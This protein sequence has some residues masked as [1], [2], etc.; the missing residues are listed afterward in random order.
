MSGPSYPQ[1]RLEVIAALRSLGDPKHQRL[2]WGRWR[3]GVEYYD[4]LALDIHILYDDTGVLP[5]PEGATPAVLFPAE[6][7][8]FRALAAALGPLIDEH[9]ERGEEV[10]LRDPRWASVIAAASE[11]LAVMEQTEAGSA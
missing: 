8:A 9:G 4:D 3:E 7:S 11:A 6:V 2:Q 10:Y 5:H 1:M